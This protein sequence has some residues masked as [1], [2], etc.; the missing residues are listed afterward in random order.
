[1]KLGW[2]TGTVLS[3]HGA[4]SAIIGKDTRLSGY[5]FEACLEAGFSAA[6]IKTGL[7][8]V[9][10]TPAVAY[11]TR[12]LRA[13][14]GVVI[15]ASHNPYHDNGI[16]LFSSRGYKLP[17]DIEAEIEAVLQ[18]DM[19]LERSDSIGRAYRVAGAHSRYIEFCKSSVPWGLN[20]TGLK[21]L[22]D[23]ANG[24]TYKVAPS[25]LQELGAEVDVIANE[26]NGLN[27]NKEC[28]STHPEALIEKIKT[29]NY[30]IG[31]AFDGDGDRLILVT[32]SGRIIDGDEMLYLIAMDRRMNGHPVKDVVG[33][34]M[35]NLGVEKSLMKE[36][37]QLHRAN[38]G[39]RYVVEKMKEVGCNLG[40]ESSG[41]I[42]CLD[43]TTTGDGIISALQVLHLIHVSGKSL[44]SLLAD[45]KKYPQQMTNVILPKKE[46][47]IS[48]SKIQEAIASIEQEFG[49]KGRVLLRASGTEPLIRVMTEGENEAQVVQLNNK[50]VAA[51]EQVIT[52]V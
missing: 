40:G 19:K 42:I 37:I 46:D 1:M 12:T 50:L 29:A 28:G 4:G 5:L 41:H 30:D 8:G 3:K 24:A 25:V 34:V 7:I 16:K 21:V 35:T 36:N 33:T 32:S 13:D 10:P 9:I 18:A 20:L 49:E 17:D 14:V 2:A 22:V 47:V 43:K 31:I 45:V 39:D 51:V 48:T 52:E 15:S 6:G 11:L 26:P 38:V 44:E 27:I 23:V